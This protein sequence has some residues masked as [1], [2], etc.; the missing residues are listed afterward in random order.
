MH[1]GYHERSTKRS[2]IILKGARRL[3]ASTLAA[4]AIIAVTPVMAVAATEM[5]ALAPAIGGALATIP[6]LAPVAIAAM[7]HIDGR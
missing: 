3:L 6:V 5:S 2:H 4:I 1:D 7:W